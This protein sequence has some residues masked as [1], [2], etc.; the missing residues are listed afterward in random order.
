MATLIENV[1]RITDALNDIKSAIISKGV[2]PT[3][4]AETFAEAIRNIPQEGGGTDVSDTTAIES[5]VVAGKRFHKADGSPANGTIEDKR[6]A[7]AGALSFSNSSDN[8][9]YFTHP[10]LSDSVIDSSSKSG[11]NRASLG[12]ATAENVQKGIF[13]TSSEG[14][15]L[16]G[17]MEAGGGIPAIGK[18]NPIYTNYLANMGAGSTSAVMTWQGKATTIV[19][20]RTRR[21]GASPSDNILYAINI[22]DDGTATGC[23][24]AGTGTAVSR[25]D[26]LPNN[27]IQQITQNSLRIKNPSGSYSMDYS[28]MVFGIGV[29]MASD[30]G[31]K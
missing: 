9:F 13:F 25:Y 8:Y 10:S 29:E 16:E 18:V 7:T 30:A 17:T 6:G 4:K 22:D 15:N 20:R 23:Y 5:D 31:G 21:S 24:L 14:I 27:E 3:G 19:M 28:I 26:T 11:I 1:R 2:T 12:D